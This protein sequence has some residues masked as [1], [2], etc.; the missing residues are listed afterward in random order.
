MKWIS[1]PRQCPIFLSRLSRLCSPP[2][3]GTEC[4]VSPENEGGVDSQVRAGEGSNL[5]LARAAVSL[6]VTRGVYF[7][8]TVPNQI[9]TDALAQWAG[10]PKTTQ[11][12]PGVQMATACP[13]RGTPSASVATCGGVESPDVHKCN[14]GSSPL[15]AF[16]EDLSLRRPRLGLV[17]MQLRGHRERT[18]P[19]PTPGRG[20]QTNGRTHERTDGRTHARTGKWECGTTG[21]PEAP[22]RAGWG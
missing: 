2:V 3:P 1:A 21:R 9:A 4:P 17:A 10:P 19:S 15:P 11:P 8:R 7:A 22:G 16:V 14:R 5:G 6:R 20:R 12:L 18:E 13:T